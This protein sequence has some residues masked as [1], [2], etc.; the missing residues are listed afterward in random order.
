MSGKEHAENSNQLKMFMSP[1]EIMQRNWSKTEPRPRAVEAGQRTEGDRNDL[2][3]VE[4]VT[5]EDDHFFREG[6]HG[7][8]EPGYYHYQSPGEPFDSVKYMST[9]E[10]GR[11]AI[12]S[13]DPAKEEPYGKY[14]IYFDDDPK[15]D[16]DYYDEWRDNTEQWGPLPDEADH[17]PGPIQGEM[18]RQVRGMADFL[19]TNVDSRMRTVSLLGMAERHQSQNYGPADVSHSLTPDSYGLLKRIQGAEAG[20]KYKSVAWKKGYEPDEPSEDYGEM[21]VDD[22]IHSSVHAD[23]GSPLMETANVE[24]NLAHPKDSGLV[25]FTEAEVKEGKRFVREQWTSRKKRGKKIP[26]TKQAG[27]QLNLFPQT[28]REY[29]EANL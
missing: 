4:W 9:D 21:R 23:W 26:A 18:F 16:P 12:L 28:A 19:N 17:E 3:P 10:H 22:P 7:Q 29:W 25:K 15:N 14:G 5:P 1:R 2:I 11:G 24:D 20:K 13:V 8:F 6:T 27:T